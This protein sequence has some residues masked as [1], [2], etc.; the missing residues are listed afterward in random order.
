MR[1][2]MFIVMASLVLAGCEPAPPNSAFYNYGGPE[3]LLDTSS[4]VVSLNIA[5]AADM[6]SLSTWV[7]RDKPSRA[8]LYC[9][10]GET[11]CTE[12]QKLL[13]LH[14]V[15]SM[16]VPSTD[17]SVALVYERVVAR[18]CDPR[19]LDSSL[20]KHWS[21]SPEQGCAVAA[22]IVQHVSDKQQFV[23]PALMENP[24]ATGPVTTYN[25]AYQTQAAGQQQ[26]Q[27]YNLQQSTL[28]QGSSQ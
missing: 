27:E 12:A 6:K 2:G 5:S 19:Y 22:N 23:S 21:S 13:D 14:G 1:K 10:K 9:N 16:T 28:S 7:S 4:E 8:E 26:S 17:N 3:Q 18:D 25:S 11:H 20:N 24:R 15:P